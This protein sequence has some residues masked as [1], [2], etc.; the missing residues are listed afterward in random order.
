MKKNFTIRRGALD[1]IEIFLAAARLRNFR[2]AAAELGITPSAVGQAVRALEMRLGVAL[3]VRTTRSV[4]M[5]EA[6]ERF[7]AE[8]EPAYQAL[9]A[10]GAAASDF[11]G[12]PA[13]LLRIALPRAVVPLIIRPVLA[14]FAMAYPDIELEIAASE[15]FVD[16][17]ALGFDAGMRMG[18][19]IAHDM[20]AMRLTP[21]I[22]M[23]VVASPDYLARRGTPLQLEDLQR[24]ACLRLRR[25]AGGA[26]PWRFSAKG[27]PLEV[28]TQGPLIAGDFLTLLDAAI[29]GV[30]LIQAPEPVVVASCKAGALREVLAGFAPQTPGVF[31]YY[32]DRRQVLPKLRV[33]IDHLKAHLPTTPTLGEVES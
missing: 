10:A 4:G 20:I 17:A 30:G 18:Q 28:M 13:G 3:F 27:G 14:S 16:I 7:L 23:V 5:T 19:H 1:G 15:E 2:R 12:R 25:S 21:P 33:F 6:G 26:S 11:G 8:A 32:P 9:A 29:D 24:H 22:K 31:L